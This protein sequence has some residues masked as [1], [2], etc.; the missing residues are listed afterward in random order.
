MDYLEPLWNVLE[1]EDKIDLNSALSKAKLP[2]YHGRMAVRDVLVEFTN[3]WKSAQKITK[4]IRPKK[5]ERELKEL[6]NSELFG[7][8][9]LLE[10]CE[11]S[12][13]TPEGLDLHL[14]WEKF[15]YCKTVSME[16]PIFDVN[17]PMPIIPP[18]TYSSLLERRMEN[19]GKLP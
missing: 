17:N 18:L 2:A 10:K 3:R 14:W 6:A 9:I 12:P 1:Q 7:H 4:Q 5:H 13:I 11:D 8:I 16:N 19:H 15:R